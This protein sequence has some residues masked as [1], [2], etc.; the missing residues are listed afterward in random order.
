MSASV[1]TMSAA[2]EELTA[3][4]SEISQSASTAATVATDAVATSEETAEAVRRL[5]E[6]SA[7][8]GDILKV[9]TSIA[10]Q[11]N[12]LALNATIEAARAGDAGKGF[13]VVAGEV[14]D[15][16]QDGGHPSDDTGR[17]P[18]DQPD[19]ECREPDQRNADDNRGCGRRT[20]RHG[21]GDQPQRR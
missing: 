4:I 12:L 8:I 15:L 2:T 19:H 1:T 6:A 17:Q 5:D 20:I 11:T 10:E 18:G 14:K 21:V 9:I 13:A 16:P 7:E 3:S